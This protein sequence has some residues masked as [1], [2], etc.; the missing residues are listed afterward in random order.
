MYAG[1]TLVLPEYDAR[2][3]AATGS[4]VVYGASVLHAVEPVTAGRRF[5]L[6]GFFT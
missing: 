5:A 1:G 6:V 3:D 2:F 4:A